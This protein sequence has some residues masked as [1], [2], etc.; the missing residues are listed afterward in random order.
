MENGA[1]YK[2]Q[3]VHLKIDVYHFAIQAS[4]AII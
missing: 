3:N 4:V 2:N 1:A